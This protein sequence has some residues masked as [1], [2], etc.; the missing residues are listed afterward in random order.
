MARPKIDQAKTRSRLAPRRAPYWGAPVGEPRVTVGVRVTPAGQYWIG[1]ALPE[2]DTHRFEALGQ[3]S[4]ENDY[5]AACEK[6]RQ[7]GRKLLASVDTAECKTVADACK[8]YIEDR[9]RVKGNSTARDAELRFNRT[10]KDEPLGALALDRLRQAILEKW[11]D[12]LIDPK[13]HHRL[14]KASANRTL[15]TLKAALN[16]ACD[17]RYVTRE[18]EQEWASVKPFPNASNR[19][20]LFLDSAQRRALLDAATGAVRDLIEATMRTGARVGELVKA[21]RRDFD[22][23]QGTLRLSGKTGERAIA[24]PPQSV[25]FF[26]R[27]AKDK[28]PGAYLFTR[29]D[30]KPWGPS[31][32]DELVRDAATAAKLPAGVCLYTLRHSFITQ[33]LMDGTL[34]LLSCARYVGTS[35]TMIEKHYGQ[36]AA[37]H[38]RDRLASA[39]LV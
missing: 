10:I 9:R 34:D 36:V 13:G 3:V 17:R 5:A 33:V 19:R 39:S 15:T 2:G 37:G 7:W 38:I 28:L 23:D 31:D 30:G 25:A 21:Q 22:P 29:N 6:A 16:Y 8:L 12:S 27:L 24:L 32:W 20:S 18:R 26:K 14:S 1:R 11:R 4:D 35:A